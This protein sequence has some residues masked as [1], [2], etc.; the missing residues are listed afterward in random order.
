MFTMLKITSFGFHGLSHSLKG[1]NIWPGNNG[2]INTVLK[3]EQNLIFFE[4][5]TGVEVRKKT[6]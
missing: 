4:N 2:P 6:D 5:M 1:D 3:F